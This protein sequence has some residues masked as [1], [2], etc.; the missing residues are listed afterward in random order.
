MATAT[1]LIERLRGNRALA[2]ALGAITAAVV[3]VIANLGVWFAMHFLFARTVRLD[4]GPFDAALPDWASLDV[5]ALALTVVLGAI[6]WRWKIG[7]GPLLLIGIGLGFA[8][9]AVL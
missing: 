5:A 1:G 3:G 6:A 4:A 7:I 8:V 9:R 2:S